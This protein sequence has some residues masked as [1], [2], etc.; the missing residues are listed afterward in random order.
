MELKLD[1]SLKDMTDRVALVD[2]IVESTPKEKLTPFYL[3]I[4]ADYIM[5]SLT[6]EERKEKAYMTENR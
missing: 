6:K 1:Y 2:K 4:L 5:Q 3:E